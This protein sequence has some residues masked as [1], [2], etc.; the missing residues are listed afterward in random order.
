MVS[1]WDVLVLS[2]L[3]RKRSPNHVVIPEES[4]LIQALGVDSKKILP[5]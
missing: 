2:L 5:E 1:G 3:V 4:F